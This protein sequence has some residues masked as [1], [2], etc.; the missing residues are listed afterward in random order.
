[1]ATRAA[2][3]RE[4]QTD[5]EGRAARV[6][7]GGVARNVA[8][9]PPHPP[10]IVR[11]EGCEIEDIAG[12]RLI[13]LQNNYT[14]LV[15]GH[16]HPRIVAAATQAFADGS[17]FGLP[18]PYEVA[19][20]EELTARFPTL[21]QM[22]FTNSGTEAVMMALRLARHVTGRSKVMRFAGAYHGSYDAV[23]DASGRSPGLT[24]E[25]VVV[26]YG[27]V[28]A[29]R[30]ALRDQGEQ[31]AAVLFDPLP[32][33]LALQEPSGE[34]LSV[35]QRDARAHGALLIVDEVITGR[36]AFEGFHRVYGLEPD[37]VTLG[38]MI[39]GGLPIGA[40]G[41]PATVMAGLDPKTPG[42][43]TQSGTFS[44]NP[45]TLRAGMEAM[46]LLD[47]AAV[48]HLNHLGDLL[49]Q[50]LAAHG[51]QVRGRGSL[52]RLVVDGQPDR[53]WWRLYERGLA[54]G[55]NLLLCTSTAMTEQTIEDVARRCAG[56]AVG[57]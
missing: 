43:T 20:A 54:V 5:L 47:Q 14:T 6:L 55:S 36:L 11:G 37:L 28:D 13:D 44:A 46:R 25:V 50:E 12:R 33:R 39:G 8:Y 27:D 24:N 29:V 49:R 35:L 32:N 52:V 17:C 38:K 30:A 3:E 15:H 31:L 26:P 40:F 48:D 16:A 10:Y 4:G 2:A 42:T 56:L 22:R 53:L 51:F 41:G 21:E 45:A 57:D 19:F 23:I 18:T 7:P 1:M 9:V 34:F